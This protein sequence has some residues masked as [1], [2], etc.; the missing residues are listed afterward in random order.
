MAAFVD[1]LAEIY[2][3]DS[4]DKTDKQERTKRHLAAFVRDR[5]ASGGSKTSAIAEGIQIIQDV[6]KLW[7]KLG[8]EE[9]CGRADDVLERGGLGALDLSLPGIG[10]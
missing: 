2:T 3:N 4:S 7:R 6:L 10:G 5:L 8:D 1:G 9:T